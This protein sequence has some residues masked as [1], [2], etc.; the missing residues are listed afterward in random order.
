MVLPSQP[1]AHTNP[2][3][4]SPTPQNSQ[5]HQTKN[6]I[7]TIPIRKKTKTNTKPHQHRQLSATNSK[8]DETDS[9]W[10][11]EPY[12]PHITP[13]PNPA[14]HT[15]NKTNIDEHNN[16]INEEKTSPPPTD[17]AQT[18]TGNTASHTPS[19]TN[20]TITIANPS[21]PNTRLTLRHDQHE[22]S[23]PRPYAP[24]LSPTHHSTTHRRHVATNHDHHPPTRATPNTIEQP[25]KYHLRRHETSSQPRHTRRAHKHHSDRKRKTAHKLHTTNTR[26]NPNPTATF[27]NHKPHSEPRPKNKSTSHRNHQK[28]SHQLKKPKHRSPKQ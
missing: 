3:P 2:V 26:R 27:A 22:R 11:H 17:T 18:C 15:Q 6:T 24:P 10:S 20:V 16:T 9:L 4:P 14:S 8:S 7:H 25:H 5:T 28:H 13:A 1:H 23:R 21:Q 12:P 19:D